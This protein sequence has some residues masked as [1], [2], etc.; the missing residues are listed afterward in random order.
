M[1]HFEPDPALLASMRIT[2][3]PILRLE[4]NSTDHAEVLARE[5]AENGVLLGPEAIVGAFP[6]R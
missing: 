6:F 3:Q 4:D 5:A 1:S 2:Y